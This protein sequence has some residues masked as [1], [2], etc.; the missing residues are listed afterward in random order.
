[1]MLLLGRL[2]T[3]LLLLP[4]PRGKILFSLPMLLKFLTL[5]LMG[6][7]VTEKKPQAGVRA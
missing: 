7:F 1:M 3:L 5:R 2:I 4:K 6:R